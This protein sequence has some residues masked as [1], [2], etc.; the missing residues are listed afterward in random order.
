MLPSAQLAINNRDNTST[1]LSPF[2]LEHG[3]HV[4]PIQLTQEISSKSLTT[5]ANRAQK[6]MSRLVEAQ[7][8]ASAAM[9]AAQQRME[10]NANKSR[11]PAPQFRVGDKVWLCLKN[12]QTPQPKKKLAWV[13]AKYSVTRIISP[14]VVELDVP[15]K[16]HPRFHVELLRKASED[17][18]PSQQ[19]EDSQPPPE[20]IDTEEGAIP[21]Q[22]VERILRADKFRRGRGWVRRVLVKWKNFAEPSWEDRADLEDVEALDQFEAK[23]GVG[24]SVGEDEGARQGSSR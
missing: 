8:Y 19:Q 1:G 20:I 12:I 21:E 16:I 14:H 23:Y 3:Y 18:L 11:N 5:P 24:D 4:E 17:P 13:N 6:F 2:F 15:S 10:E 9:A 7:E 22:V